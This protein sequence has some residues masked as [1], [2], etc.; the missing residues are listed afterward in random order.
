MT[1]DKTVSSVGPVIDTETIVTEHSLAHISGEYVI[2]QYTYTHMH[3]HYIHSLCCYVKVRLQK[4]RR[5]CC[6]FQ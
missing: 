4:K 6:N 2:V 3:K 5:Y 1:V